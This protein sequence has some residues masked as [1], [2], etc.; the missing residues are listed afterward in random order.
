MGCARPHAVVTGVSSGIGRATALRLATAGYHV[1]G[2]VRR[3]EDGTWLAAH[4]TPL[5]LEV[6]DAAQIAD[7]AGTVAEHAGAA[8]LAALVDNAGIGVTGPLELTPLD[9]I[10]RQF[11]VNVLGQ[12]AVTQAFLPLLRAARGRVVLIGSIGDRITIPFG[13]PLAASKSALASIADALRMEL[14]PWDVRAVLVEPAS[15]ST[16]AVGKLE[17]DAAR[18]AGQF[19]ADPG[20]RKTYLEMVRRMAAM[21]RRGS[22]PAVV[23][24]AVAAALAARR[25]RARYLVGRDA[26]RLAVLARLP[27]PVLDA[28]RRGLFGLPAPGSLASRKP[29]GPGS[30]QAGRMRGREPRGEA[31]GSATRG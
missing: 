31:P 13:G 29:A 25:P 14:A 16:E 10:R 7:A 30:S 5:L 3:L 22:P 8:G 11:E 19:V 15:I 4:V 18:A 20:Y 1:Y 17:R 21:E 9:A 23:A 27:V 12:V 26:R 2:G 24:D 28:V 6:T